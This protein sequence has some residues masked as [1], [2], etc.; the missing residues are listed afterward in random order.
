MQHSSFYRI[1]ETDVEK[2]IYLLSK[3]V[4]MKSSLKENELDL[5]YNDLRGQITGLKEKIGDSH[6]ALSNFS[7]KIAACSKRKEV[8]EAYGAKA[9]KEVRRLI[10]MV[11]TVLNRINKG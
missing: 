8:S 2:F 1:S 6:Q 10:G 5:E 9:E 3:K 4:V 7:R 11:E